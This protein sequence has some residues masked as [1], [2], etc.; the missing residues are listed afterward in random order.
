MSYTKLRHLASVRF[1]DITA[2]PHYQLFL[3]AGTKRDLATFFFCVCEIDIKVDKQR[4]ELPF[5]NK[6]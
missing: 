6:N 1:S 4:Q 3:M 2:W 5:K